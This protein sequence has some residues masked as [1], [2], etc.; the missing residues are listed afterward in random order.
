MESP[1]LRGSS[2]HGIAEGTSGL[3]TL[4]HSRP[5]ANGPHLTFG[6]RPVWGL[7]PSTAEPSEPFGSVGSVWGGSERE[8][9]TKG[10][11]T[12]WSVYFEP[13]SRRFLGPPNGLLL[14]ALEGSGVCIGAYG[15]RSMPWP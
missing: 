10:G 6:F 11:A 15:D 9:D 12:V 4:F 2:F 13:E 14:R 7:G 8:A 1:V 3:A 5:K